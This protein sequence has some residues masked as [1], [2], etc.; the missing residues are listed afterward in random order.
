MT[1]H[2]L[3]TG[4]TGFIGTALVRRLSELGHHVRVLDDDSRGRSSR[5]ADVARH[6]EIVH[7]D[8]RNAE[9]VRQ[10]AAGMDGVIH[11]AAVNGTEFF[12]S[13][14]ELVLDVSIR[15][16]LNVIDACRSE[17]IGDLVIASSSEVYQT[18]DKLPTDEIVPISIPDVRNPRYSYAGGKILNELMG[19]NY[20]RTGFDRV[21]VFRPHNVYGPDMGWEHVLPQLALK[22]ADV[23]AQNPN[24]AV[25]LVIQGD[26]SQSRAFMH[27]T[28][29]TNGL[30]KVIER[31]KHLEIYHIGTMEEVTIAEVSKK[32]IGWFG[33]EAKLV[34]SAIPDGGTPRRCPDI[35]KLRALGFEPGI[36]LDQGL[37]SLVEWYVANKDLR[38]K[39]AATTA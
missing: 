17:G 3:V 1:K 33:R 30:M 24:G 18:P 36:S 28:D 6:I 23:V 35:T 16:M 34:T 13:R 31:G 20:G 37:P 9:A 12:Y 21:V 38:P 29:F 14:P 27:I 2:Y 8:I 15:G 32:V 19:L 4:G 5:L 11:L 10:A 26:G 39:P 22:A 7:G 25:P